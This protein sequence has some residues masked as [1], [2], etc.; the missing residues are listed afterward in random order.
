MTKSQRLLD[1]AIASNT[2]SQSA[3]LVLKTLLLLSA[4]GLQPFG[5]MPVRQLLLCAHL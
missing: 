4:Q 2:A 5:E 1:A 3:L